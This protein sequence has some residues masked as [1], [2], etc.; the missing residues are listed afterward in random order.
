MDILPNSHRL[1]PMSPLRQ[2]NFMGCLVAELYI[3]LRTP[4]TRSPKFVN[5]NGLTVFSMWSVDKFKLA[6]AIQ[7]IAMIILLGVVAWEW[8][9]CRNLLWRWK[10]SPMGSVLQPENP[11]PDFHLCRAH[12][13]SVQPGLGRLLQ[14]QQN[15]QLQLGWLNQTVGPNAFHFFGNFPLRWRLDGLQCSVRSTYPEYFC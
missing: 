2:A 5:S 6:N 3:F 14:L 7:L 15:P 9:H 13:W 4:S 8:K 1:A 11:P 10:N 12:L